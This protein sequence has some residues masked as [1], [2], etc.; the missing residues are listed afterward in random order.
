MTKIENP[1][2]CFTQQNL[3]VSWA[4][5]HPLFPC[6]PPLQRY[7]VSARVKPKANAH[8]RHFRGAWFSRPCHSILD[9]WQT[10]YCI[11]TSLNS[12]I[13]ASFH[14]WIRGN[15]ILWYAP[16]AS[17]YEVWIFYSSHI[18]EG[19]APP[20]S[21]VFIIISSTLLAAMTFHIM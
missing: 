9:Y 14:T 3:I 10:H 16:H 1:L 6:H 18:K 21:E 19:N 4:S 13:I 7:L 11:F 2:A 12:N 8:A 5:L 20:D 15:T 17:E